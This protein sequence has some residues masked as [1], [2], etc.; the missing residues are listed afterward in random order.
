MTEKSRKPKTTRTRQSMHMKQV[1][2]QNFRCGLTG[3]K[4]NARTIYGI[5]KNPVGAKTPEN[6]LWV[7]R[8]A[9]RLCDGMSIDKALSMMEEILR[10]RRPE[11]FRQEKTKE[12]LMEEYL[13]SRHPDLFPAGSSN[14][15]PSTVAES[16]D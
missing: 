14:D 16:Q 4:L 2:A 8:D 10:F 9:G 7:D 6:I 5:L 12:E 3:R 15:D 11:L 13:Q 1:K